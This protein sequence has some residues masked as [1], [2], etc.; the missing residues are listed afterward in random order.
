MRRREIIRKL[1]ELDAEV[2][3]SPP[4]FSSWVTIH[5]D[6]E[7]RAKASAQIEKLLPQVIKYL[8]AK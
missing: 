8:E 2:R 3:R 1:K 6:V 5:A 7:R 4:I